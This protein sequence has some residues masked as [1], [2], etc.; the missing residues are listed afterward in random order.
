ML[1]L[2]FFVY[3]FFFAFISVNMNSTYIDDPVINSYVI[4][5]RFY[6]STKDMLDKTLGFI[7][8]I[9]GLIGNGLVIYLMRSSSLSKLTISIYLISLAISDSIALLSDLFVVWLDLIQENFSLQTLTDCKIYYFN[10]VTRLLSSWIIM[11]ISMDRFLSVFYPQKTRKF[12]SHKYCLIRIV[13]LVTIAVATNIHY[14]VIIRA[15][16]EVTLDCYP[17]GNVATIYWYE[18]IWPIFYIILDSILPSTLLII[19]NSLII[20]KTKKSKKN[21][22]QSASQNKK[23]ERQSQRKMSLTVFAICF[24]FLVLTLPLNLHNIFTA[25]LL[26][27]SDEYASENN[28]SLEYHIKRHEILKQLFIDRLLELY[29]SIVH[30]I[31]FFLYI[32]TSNL[33][34]NQFYLLLKLKFNIN[35]FNNRINDDEIINSNSNTNTNTNGYSN[36]RHNKESLKL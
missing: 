34:R 29:M 19:F 25:N 18:T 8:L 31:N 10:F 28:N 1:F 13:L 35:L 7:I 22:K 15:P 6:V 17:V 26:S 23:Q 2:T 20:Y 24:S 14:L 4:S 33:F 5:C 32:M 30:G 21:I 16:A 12:L 9:F 3:N 27:Q 11:T 36:T